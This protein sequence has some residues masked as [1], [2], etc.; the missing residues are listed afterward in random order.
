M[1]PAK[2]TN[3]TDPFANWDRHYD[4]FKKDN[5]GVSYTKVQMERIAESLKQGASHPTLGRNIAKHE[6][7]WDAGV[8]TFDR[9]RNQFSIRKNSKVVDY[10]CGSLR[11][12]GHFIRFLDPGCYFGLDL[13]R[14]LYEIGQDVLGPQMLAEKAPRFGTVE[15]EALDEAVAFGADFV[16]ST[17]V[18]FHVH[19]DEMPLYHDN[20]V[21]LTA[22]PGAVLVFDT[23]ISE[24]P[25]RYRERAWAWPLQTYLEALAPLQ[26]VR[27][28]K[29]AER[30]EMG[31]RFENQILEFR[32][33]AETGKR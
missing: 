7:W 16:F 28:T 23:K 17:S 22:K 8:S 15:S 9:Y 3:E 18:A 27:A 11:V 12:G 32:R 19:P 29:L 10:G 1:S 26:F 25:L 31:V 24:R 13:A 33:T 20:L 30:T 14:G 6:D 2:S 21:K 4:T 5:P